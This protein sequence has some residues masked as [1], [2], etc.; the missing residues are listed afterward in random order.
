MSLNLLFI[1]FTLFSSYLPTFVAKPE[2]AADAL[3]K[4]K[5]SLTNQNNPLLS[6][7]SLHP[8]TN[9]THVNR[10]TSTAPCTWYGVHCNDQG[11]V[12][13]LNLSTSRLNG[14]L[15]H[16]TFSSFASLTHLDLRLNDVFG[17]IPVG[18]RYLS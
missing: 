11:D 16:F 14:T 13:K 12:V 7:W 9:L 18:I 6:S 17:S 8:T 15:Q 1:L 10:T 4:W 2:A 3:L 5:T